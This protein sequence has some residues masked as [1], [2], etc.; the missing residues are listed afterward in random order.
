[1]ALNPRAELVRVKTDLLGY[2]NIDNEVDTDDYEWGKVKREWLPPKPNE[3][4]DKSKLTRTTEYTLNSKQWKNHK[5]E[6]L[7]D[8]DVKALLTHG[9]LVYGMAGTG[10]S[11]TLKK[12]RDVL[13]DQNR[14]I[15]A[16]THKASEIV[17]GSTLHKLLGVDVKH[18]KYDMKL[19]KSYVQRGTKYFFIDEVSMVPSWMWN[20]LSHIKK[21]HG[22]I[23]IGC[24]DW[25]QLAPVEEE[26]M[27]FEN[28]WL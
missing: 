23:F 22:F 21:Q 15:G 3:L 27:D 17:D 1:M 5:R 11:T 8:D 9:G 19:V 13:T 4:M 25:K 10:K 14:I 16:F 18:H 2:I 20:I 7:D 28:S 12:I 6:V 26:D 24:G